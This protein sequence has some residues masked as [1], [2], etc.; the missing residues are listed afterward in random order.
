MV[1]ENKERGVQLEP[2][3]LPSCCVRGHSRWCWVWITSYLLFPLL[4]FGHFPLFHL[5]GLLLLL[6]LEGVVREEAVEGCEGNTVA[7]TFVI[8]VWTHRNKNI[9]YCYV[10]YCT[11]SGYADTFGNVADAVK[12][13]DNSA[14]N[15]PESLHWQMHCGLY[16]ALLK[17]LAD[18][19][20]VDRQKLT[21]ILMIY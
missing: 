14:C 18:S 10:V 5:L 8:L 2:N 16:T 15:E 9:I 20:F 6:L 13:V 4:N 1:W 3:Y 17:W 19:P 7:L 21:T 12:F 11:H